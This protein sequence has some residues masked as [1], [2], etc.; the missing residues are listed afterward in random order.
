MKSDLGVWPTYLI[1]FLDVNSDS[2][3]LKGMVKNLE[4]ISSSAYSNGV[5]KD[6]VSTLRTS[7]ESCFFLF[8]NPAL[9]N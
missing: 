8:Q 3:Y 2:N 1:V 4:T 5:Y 6:N 9:I 7:V